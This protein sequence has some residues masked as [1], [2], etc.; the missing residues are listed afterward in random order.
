MAR[1]DPECHPLA[2]RIVAM[3]FLATPHR[4]SD[5]ATFLNRILRLSALH[6]TRQ[7]ISNLERCSSSLVKINDTFRNYCND[8]MLYSYF[9]TKELRI[10]VGSSALIV[11]KDSA[12]AGLPGERVSMLDAD[13]RSICKF[14]SSDDPNY[15]ILTDA[16]A[17]INR[18]LAQKCTLG[19]LTA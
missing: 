6:G 5:Y 8:L 7:Y 2:A 10:G 14:G 19:P 4:G 13:H 16:F 18:E 11:Q 12:I 1:Q 9:E 17:T 3:V 15:L